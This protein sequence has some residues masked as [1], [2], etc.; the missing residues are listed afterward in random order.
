MVQ[1]DVAYLGQLRCD[2]RHGPSGMRLLTD[3]PVD[4]KGRG[5]AFSPTDLLATALGTC[6]LT[7]MGIRAQEQSYPLE[8]TTLSVAKHMT[9]S[10]PRR[11]A[12]LEVRIRVPRGAELA[13]AAR[14]A[15]EH[16]AHHCPVRLSIHDALEVPVEFDWGG[17]AG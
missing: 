7:I 4:N 15:L 11:V 12:R 17:A 13:D 6:M 8:G 5:E 10:G 9:Q 3:A 2:A 14:R 16:A 1:I